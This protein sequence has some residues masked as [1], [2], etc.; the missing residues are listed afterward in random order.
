[1]EVSSKTVKLLDSIMCDLYN[2]TGRSRDGP[3]LCV[4]IRVKHIIPLLIKPEF[5][6]LS[7]IY[8]MTECDLQNILYDDITIFDK[9]KL[10]KWIEMKF[11]LHDFCISIIPLIKINCC[12]VDILAWRKNVI[13]ITPY[14][15]DTAF[16][17]IVEFIKY[18]EKLKEDGRIPS[19][20]KY[21]E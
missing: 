21:S 19:N 6:D 18:I 1:M 20:T 13:V 8:G 4:E 11:N 5:M 2:L 15:G 7:D 14:I 9:S 10:T 16:T 17:D 3:L 12:L